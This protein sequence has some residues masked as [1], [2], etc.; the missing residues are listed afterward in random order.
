MVNADGS[1]RMRLSTGAHEYY[2]EWSPN[3][4]KIAFVSYAAVAGRIVVMNAD[5]TAPTTIT[6]GSTRDDYEPAWAPDGTRLAFAGNID[7]TAPAL[8]ILAPTPQ[9]VVKQKNVQVA[10]ACDEPCGVRASGVVVIAGQRGKIRLRAA[11]GSFGAFTTKRLKLRLSG[12]ALRRIGAA[13]AKRKRATRD[14]LGPAIDSF[15]NARHED[16]KSQAE[17]VAASDW[18]SPSPTEVLKVARKGDEG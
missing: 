11:S 6:S 16:A 10:I 17:A 9:R 7:K 14:H 15:G 4:T 8:L 1:G 5:G 18:T 12:A 3:G 2:P 13:L